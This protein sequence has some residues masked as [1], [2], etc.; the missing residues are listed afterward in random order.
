MF[1]FLKNIGP[2]EL[3]II[4]VVVVLLFGTKKIPEFAKG[5]GEAVKTFRQALLGEDKGKKKE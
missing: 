3:I 2:T 1:D 4:A 5:I